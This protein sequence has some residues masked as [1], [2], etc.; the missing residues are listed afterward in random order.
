MHELSKEMD[1]WINSFDLIGF[2]PHLRRLQGVDYTAKS[3]SFPPYNLIQDGED[4]RIEIA[5]AGY[6]TDDIEI[7]YHDGVLS[8]TG[9]Q[10]Q[11]EDNK[12]YLFKGIAQRNFVRR[13]TLA[14]TVVIDTATFDNGILT[15]HMH[16]ELPEHLKQRRIEI[17]NA[18]KK[19]LLNE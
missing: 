14:D 15:V 6:S 5:V 10:E 4:I 7:E 13:F 19:Q 17:T 3:P 18:S 9:N 8:I 12:K 11:T 1:R 16:N 2:D